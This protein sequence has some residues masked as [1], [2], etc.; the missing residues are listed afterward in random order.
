MTKR[1][2][3][4]K[5][6]LSRKEAENLNKQ[7][8]KCRLSREAYLRHLITGEVPREAPPPEYFAFMREMHY[9][10]HNLN[11]IAQKA[12]V[13]NVVDAKRYQRTDWFPLRSVHSQCNPGQLRFHFQH[14]YMLPSRRLPCNNMG[15][16]GREK[17]PEP[18]GFYHLPAMALR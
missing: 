4:I 13:L 18:T 7:V 1:N 14:G 3:E 5:V 8:K 11:Q 6:R 17:P 16:C 15:C 2:I 10:G 12:H 9:V